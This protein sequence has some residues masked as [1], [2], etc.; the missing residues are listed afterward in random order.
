M[1]DENPTLGP[2]GSYL[3]V[4]KSSGA[5]VG[6]TACNSQVKVMKTGPVS[7]GLVATYGKRVTLF[8]HKGTYEKYDFLRTH[9]CH[10]YYCWC[11][12]VVVAGP[13]WT[14]SCRFSRRVS[15]C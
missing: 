6:L 8:T 2:L 10:I 9:T 12:V 15:F 4:S 11:V 1:S 13:A 7:S 5:L 3:G 14:L